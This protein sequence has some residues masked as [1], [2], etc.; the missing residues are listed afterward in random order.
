MKYEEERYK[1]NTGAGP[2]AAISLEQRD[3]GKCLDIKTTGICYL[4]KSGISS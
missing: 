1:K 2:D 3:V 4:D